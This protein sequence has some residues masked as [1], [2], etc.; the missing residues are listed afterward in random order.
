MT[1][2]VSGFKIK[3]EPAVYVSDTPGIIIPKIHNPM[4]AMKLCLCNCIRDGIVEMEVLCDYALFILNQQKQFA[5]VKR[6]N[7]PNNLPSDDIHVLLHS[8]Q[9]RMGL[10]DR[11]AT[12]ANFLDDFRQGKLG[13]V[14]LD[15]DL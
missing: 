3:S 9:T 14:Y 10:R 2:S 11:A 1:K 12:Y 7:L 6:Y 4:D 13:K 15:D 5:Y 8:V